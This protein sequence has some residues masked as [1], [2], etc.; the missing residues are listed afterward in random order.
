MTGW[1][2]SLNGLTQ[3]GLLG[4]ARERGKSGE[5]KNE[6]TM[7]Q[8]KSDRHVVPQGRR[9][10]IPTG[11][12][13]KRRGGKVT[14]VEQQ[15]WQLGLQFGTAENPGATGPGVVV[16]AAARP[17]VPATH[18]TPKPNVKEKRATSARMEEVTNRL[19]AAFVKVASNKG[20]SGPDRQS[21]EDV[22][23]HLDTVL[24]QLEDALREET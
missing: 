19:R 8:Q 12:F 23:K 1:L 20:A 9:K 7:A 10:A 13:E 4:P 14:S 3:G 22:R 24:V 21:V 16:E 5:R 17:R 15:T 6:G 18:A 11:A 2:Q